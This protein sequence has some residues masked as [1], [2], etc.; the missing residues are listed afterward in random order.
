ME[1]NLSGWAI[2]T[3]ILILAIGYL[4]SKLADTIEQCREMRKNSDISAFRKK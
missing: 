1:I 3:A 2:S 4:A